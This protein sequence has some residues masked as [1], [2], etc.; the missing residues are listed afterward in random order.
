MPLMAVR[1]PST[2]VT[3][4]AVPFQV[5]VLPG[6]SLKVK[7]MVALWPIFTAATLLVIANV[8]ASVSMLMAGVLPAPGD[9]DPAGVAGA[10]RPRQRG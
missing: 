7:V 9:R 6:S 10:N 5:K 8:G 3:S 4:P 2:N 1:V